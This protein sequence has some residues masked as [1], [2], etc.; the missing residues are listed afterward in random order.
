[1]VGRVGG[2][3]VVWLPWPVT[4]MVVEHAWFPVAPIMVLTSMHDANSSRLLTPYQ[5]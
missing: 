5:Q 2:D 3:I 1:M 4:P